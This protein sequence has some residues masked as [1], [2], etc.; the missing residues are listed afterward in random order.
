MDAPYQAAPDV[1]VLPHNLP[2]PGIGVLPINA[3]VLL[4]EEPVLIDTGLGIDGDQFIDALTSIVDPKALVGRGFGP[5]G[6]PA[7]YGEQ[8]SRAEI[9][10]LTEYLERTSGSSSGRDTAGL[11]PASGPR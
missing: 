7:N 11:R 3:Y 2:L 4:A 9:D 6:M 1:H 8:L 10:T 5:D